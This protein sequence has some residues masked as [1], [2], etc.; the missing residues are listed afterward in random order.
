M[1]IGL[2]DSGRGG[3]L[4]A[5]AVQAHMPQ[6]DYVYYGDTANVPYGDRSESEIYEF[7]KAGVEYLFKQNCLIVVLAC[8]TASAET[9]RKLQDEWLPYN[10]PERKILGVIIPT[11]EAMLDANRKRIL[12]LATQR[13]VSAGKYHLE[14]GKLNI[15]HTK[16]VSHPAPALVP[17]IEKGTISAALAEAT[18]CIKNYTDRGEEIDGVILGCTHYSLL[19]GEL[20][21]KFPDIQFFT[22]TE[23]IPSKLDAYLEAH[24]ELETQ[25][26][27]DGLFESYFTGKD[28]T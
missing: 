10:Y 3:L 2:F 14:L 21:I 12:L 6:Y 1:K 20:R 19:V 8:N 26:T 9:L 28:H 24:P 25:L 16:I 17:M 4:V 7:T 15:L 18:V 13:T 5:K 23:I 11:V 22:Q 27:R